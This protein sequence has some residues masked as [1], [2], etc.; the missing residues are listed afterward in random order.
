MSYRRWQCNDNDNEGIK[1]DSDF[2]CRQTGEQTK[3]FQVQGPRGPKKDEE[4]HLDHFVCEGVAASTTGRE[5]HVRW[6]QKGQTHYQT[7]H[8]CMIWLSP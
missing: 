7:H 4:T 2:S 6:M 5:R 8:H 3:V 1:G